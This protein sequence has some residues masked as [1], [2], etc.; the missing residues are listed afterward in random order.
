[1]N[2][3]LYQSEIKLGIF[4]VVYSLSLL[5]RSP[6][7]RRTNCT[8]WQNSEKVILETPAPPFL[9]LSHPSP[10]QDLKGKQEKG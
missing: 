6:D 10:L 7:F 3:I 8:W 2:L 5:K 9:Y 1:M 4:P